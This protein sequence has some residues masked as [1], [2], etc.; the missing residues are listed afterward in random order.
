M[1]LPSWSIRVYERLTGPLR[2]ALAVH[3]VL[4]GQFGHALSV[5]RREPA[6]RMGRPIPWFTYLKGEYIEQL[7]FPSKR[8]FNF[9]AGNSTSFFFHREF[10][11]RPRHDRQ[12]RHGVGSLPFMKEES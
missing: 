2:T 9:C 11:F 4:R 5:R 12:P 1:K 10:A 3:R 8:L 7:D 6:D